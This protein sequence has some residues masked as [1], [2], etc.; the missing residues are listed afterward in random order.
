MGLYF[1]G[2]APWYSVD[3]GARNLACR[4]NFTVFFF[5]FFS[6]RK[7]SARSV[8]NRGMWIGRSKGCF[9]GIYIQS[10]GAQEP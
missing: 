7:T 1:S 9:S 6:W 3:G 10:H 2:V 8:S 5:L 4:D